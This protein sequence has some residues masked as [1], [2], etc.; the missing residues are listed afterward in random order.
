MNLPSQL[1]DEAFLVDYW[2]RAA[3]ATGRR[4][5]A[6]R[7]WR[8]KTAWR[9]LVGGALFLKRAIDFCGAFCALVAL[10]PV[11]AITALLIKIEDGGPLFFQQ[12]RVGL[13]G[14]HFGMWKFR[15]MV[16]NADQLKDQ[17]LANN[18]MA[19]GVTF[20]MKN[21]P[22]VTRVGRF[23]RKYSIDELPQLWNILRGEMSLVGPR[24]PVPREVAEYTPE[25]R[26]RLLAKPGLTCFWQTQ[27]RSAIP[28]EGQVMLDVAYIRSESLWVD[29]KLLFKTIPAVLFGTGAY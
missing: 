22:R 6:W 5:L 26:Q 13:A 11:F 20:K 25:Q 23:I 29:I 19:G 9:L 3:T 7:R 28:F 16:V 10:S 18:E 12:T 4:R 17:L 2:S 27:G 1:H 24:P 14:R 21:D 8:K 15:S